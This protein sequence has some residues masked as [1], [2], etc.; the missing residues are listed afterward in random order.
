MSANNSDILRQ[1]LVIAATIGVIAFNW[2]AAAGHVNNVTPEIISALHD[3]LITPAAYGFTIWSLIYF[4]MA[5]FSLYQLLPKNAEKYRGIRSLYILSCAANCAWLYFWHYDQVVVCLVVILALLATLL[6]INV[7]LKN[8]ATLGE[9]W[10]AKA[11]F[12]I[13][14]GWVTLASMVNLMVVLKYLNVVGSESFE[15]VLVVIFILLAGLA[16]VLVRITI[17]NY[18]YPLA[19]AWAVSAVAVKQGSHTLIVVA[20]AISCIVCLFVALS[21]VL[22]ANSLPRPGPSAETKPTA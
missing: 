4:G 9:F 21:F 5:A 8:S 3:T 12:G 15:T 2:L 14:F 1:I 18:I 22:T 20:A 17:A 7:K 11:P 19:V 6:A 10:L 13:Y 16:A